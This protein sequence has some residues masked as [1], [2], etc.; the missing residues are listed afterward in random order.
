LTFGVRIPIDFNR[1]AQPPFSPASMLPSSSLLK[2]DRSKICTLCALQ[3][4]RLCR[5]SRFRSRR[6]H[7]P[8]RSFY[9]GNQFWRLSLDSPRRNPELPRSPNRIN[10]LFTPPGGLVAEAMVVPVMGS[11]E[12]YG[13]LVADLAP[14][15]PRLGKSQ[16]MGVSGASPA[17]QARLRCHELEVC[18]IAMSARLT[19][20]ELAF[21]DLGGSSVGLK[22]RRGRPGIISDNRRRRELRRLGYFRRGFGLSWAP[23][24]SPWFDG[25]R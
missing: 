8:S 25:D 9:R 11:T 23:W 21:L 6:L 7:G 5:T 12:R 18:F 17:N 22:M 15:R 10:G 19:D 4:C 1:E 20:R 3:F 16:M 2:P 14:H 13:E 24:P